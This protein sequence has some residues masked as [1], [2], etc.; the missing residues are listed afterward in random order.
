MSYKKVI[1]LFFLMVVVFGI[2]GCENITGS[3]TETTTDDKTAPVITLKGEN[4]LTLSVGQ[5]YNE[6]G[7]TAT[8]DVDS[9]VTITITGT[10]NTNTAGSYTVTYTAKDS[11]GNT[12]TKTRTVTVTAT[13]TTTDTTAP[14]IT[15]T[16]NA[17][18]ALNVG[19]TYTEQGA[20][21]TDNV[22]S[23]VTVTT[24]GTVNTSTAGSYTVT[25][26]AKDKAGNTATKTRTVTVTATDTTPPVITLNG[27]A[28]IVLNIGDTYTEQGATATDN[29]DG[30]VTVQTKG[31]VNT[32]KAGTYTIAYTA[33]DTLNNSARKDRIVVVAVAA[34][35]DK[36]ND[37][38]ISFGGNYPGGNNLT[39]IGETIAEQDCAKG[40]DAQ[41]A[42]STLSKAGAGALGFDF[43]KLDA[44]GNLLAETATSWSCVKDNH[45]GLTWEVKTTTAGNIHNNANTYRWGGKTTQLTSA[46]GTV[47]ADWDTLVDGTNSETLCG[48]SDWH[49]ATEAELESIVSYNKNGP[50]VDTNYFPNMVSSYYWTSSPTSSNPNSA[51][52]LYFSTG[53]FYGRSRATAN[54]VRLVR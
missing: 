30:A 40:R 4:P 29:V 44:N 49:V 33:T 50:T 17:T 47:Y 1:R 7:A 8:D 26:T 28:S 43:N 24:T 52:V 51:W 35:T 19:D 14:V 45:T 36:L 9:T 31:T 46:F 20:T 3:T 27:K 25:Y 54:Y 34:T 11:A 16:G 5:T 53:A 12:A 13:T 41:A 22:D 23:S 39:C 21:A 2:E 48:F 38:G 18:I 37:T 6:P 10:V 32:S 15:L 42:N